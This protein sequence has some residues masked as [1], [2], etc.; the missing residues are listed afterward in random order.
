VPSLLDRFLAYVRIDTQADEHSAASPSTPGQLDL[1]RLLLEECR[2]MGLADAAMSE[3]GVV[4]ATV[5]ATVAHPAPTIAF[6]A[7]VDTSP[8]TSGKDVKPIVH[9]NWAGGDIVLPGAPGRVIRVAE[10]AEL[11]G[12]EG[13]TIITSD[14]STLLGADDKSGVA[15]IMAAAERLRE[16]REVPHGPIRLVFTCDEEVGRGT[17]HLDVAAIGAVAAYTL[18][19]GGKGEING[20]TFSADLAVVTVTGVN[21]HPSVGKGVMVNAIRILGEFL[22]GLPK[23]SLS[24]ETTAGR[25]GFVHPYAISGGVAS[26]EARV[27]LRDFDDEG[28]ADQARLLESIAA[29]LRAAHPRA[30][31]EVTTR[32]QYRNMRDGVGREPRAMALAVAAM[33]AAGIEPRLEPIRGGTDGSALT[34]L[35]LPTPNLSTGEHSPHS[36]LEWT[37]LEEMEAAVE[38]LVHLAGLWGRER[39]CGAGEG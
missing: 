23:G 22:E 8:E 26:A 4:M 25:E 1:A 29:R 38:V 5:P 21:T 31:I 9:R 2:S 18:D 39:D 16:R 35:G 28:L 32:P 34:A 12:L 19:G 15:V 36:P 10:T 14:G 13:C 33:R 20:E 17:E 7:H 24:P 37:C 27:L 11:A 3:Q 30:R 6:V